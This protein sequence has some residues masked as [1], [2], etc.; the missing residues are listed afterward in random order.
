MAGSQNNPVVDLSTIQ[1]LIQSASASAVN[2]INSLAGNVM[3]N[4][5]D[6]TN[7]IGC[8]GVGAEDLV[9]DTVTIASLILDASFS[10]K[11]NELTVRDS[12]D[13]LVID[14]MRKSKQ[15]DSMLVSTRTFA[16]KEDILYGFKKVGDIGKIGSQYIAN[17][18]STR[19]FDTIVSAITGMRVYAKSLNDNG[20]RTK[21]II[22]VMTDGQDN[23]SQ[24]F[25]A[26]DVKVL[27]DDCHKTEMFY[28]VYVGFGSGDADAKAMGFPNAKTSGSSAHDIRESMGLVSQSIIRKSQ[29]VV[30]TSNSFFT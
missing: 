24:D 28:F 25:K 19:L 20:I 26:S 15:A 18:D 3:I 11:G 27:V 30:G 1:N 12:F 16:T 6:D 5:L 9:T 29:T 10:M 21:C 8:T 14:A 7:I 2:P 22:A 13:E 23:D 4:S 17:G